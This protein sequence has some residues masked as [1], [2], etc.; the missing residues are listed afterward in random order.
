MKR[1]LLVITGTPGVGKSTLAK[2]I[3]KYLHFNRLDLHRYYK[4][5]A[6]GYNY[7]KRCYDLDFKKLITFIE[8]KKR[9]S[10]QGLILDSHLAH[11]LPRKTID[12]CLVLV[13]CFWG[14]GRC[15]FRKYL[16][17]KCRC[18]TDSAMLIM[19]QRIRA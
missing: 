13:C 9:K 2:K 16:L 10:P 6:I 7:K 5:L 17:K 15:C 14:W 19:I 1:K 8:N 18:S 3:A 4:K 11:L 12:L